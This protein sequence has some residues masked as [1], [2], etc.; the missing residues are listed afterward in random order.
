MKLCL[1]NGSPRKE[2]SNTRKILDSFLDGYACEGINTFEIYYLTEKDKWNQYYDFMKKSDIVLIGFPLYI[3][4]MP[5]VVKEF[6]EGIP[7]SS[8]KF[9]KIGFF[10]QSGF[11]ESYQIAWMNTYFSKLAERLNYA[12]L[13]VIFQGFGVSVEIMPERFYK[14]LLQNQR[15]LG[16]ILGQSSKLDEKIVENLK[17]TVELSKTGVL[18]N[19]CMIKLGLTDTFTHKKLKQNNISISESKAGPLISRI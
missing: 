3:T 5:G 6:I 2:K 14:G 8:R 19:K 12:F 11:P 16:E 1:F 7:T 15:K 10:V 9:I 13:G 4:A 17:K 18:L